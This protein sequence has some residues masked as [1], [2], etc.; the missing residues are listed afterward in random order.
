MN[1]NA[2]VRSGNFVCSKYRDKQH[3]LG[4]QHSVHWEIPDVEAIVRRI[5][6]SWRSMIR[7]I[8]YVM[9][10][11]STWNSFRL[12][13][14]LHFILSLTSTFILGKHFLWIH[15]L[16]TSFQINRFL[17]LCFRFLTH[18]PI[19]MALLSTCESYLFTKRKRKNTI[20]SKVIF[21]RLQ[22]FYKLNIDCHY[23]NQRK[24]MR[25]F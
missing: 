13:W 24:L 16:L 15:F 19:S 21:F 12:R 2:H 4:K 10:A 7:N 25:V 20:W 9:F 8:A 6:V 3:Q 1:G 14:S 17:L 11:K 5:R 22:A 23:V 18:C